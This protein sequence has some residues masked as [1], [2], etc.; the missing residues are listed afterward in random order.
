MIPG[1]IARKKN[2]LSDE[3]LHANIQENLAPEE[4]SAAPKNPARRQLLQ[5]IIP[6]LGNGLVTILR[7]GNNLKRDLAEALEKKQ[8]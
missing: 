3:E 8:P 5:N 1:T 4:F 2:P 6:S 7:A